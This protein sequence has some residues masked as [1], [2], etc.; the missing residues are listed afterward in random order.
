MESKQG[1]FAR[2]VL[3]DNKLLREEARAWLHAKIV[4]KV[5][6]GERAFRMIDFMMKGHNNNTIHYLTN[7]KCMTWCI[8]SRFC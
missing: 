6:K 2:T 8:G 1:K 5:T 4:K 3:D 7:T